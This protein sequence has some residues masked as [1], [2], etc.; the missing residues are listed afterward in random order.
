MLINQRHNQIIYEAGQDDQI[1]FT[2]MALTT[3]V[4]ALLIAEGQA[5]LRSLQQTMPMYSNT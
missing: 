4:T 1:P 3:V 2:G 5:L